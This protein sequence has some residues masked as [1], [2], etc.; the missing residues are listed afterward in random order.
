MGNVIKAAFDQARAEECRGKVC[1]IA[2]EDDSVILSVQEESGVYCDYHLTQSH[3]Q[4]IRVGDQIKFFVLSV[5][6]HNS[7]TPDED[8]CFPIELARS[9]ECE[10]IDFAAAVKAIPSDPSK[11]P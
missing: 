1:S 9:I 3:G 4:N 7:Q 2:I 11:G 5:N 10:V 6:A 8:F